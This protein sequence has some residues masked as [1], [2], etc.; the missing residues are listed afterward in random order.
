MIGSGS[1][2]LRIK[3][4][5]VHRGRERERQTGRQAD[6]ETERERNWKTG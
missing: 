5:K 6:K 2:M 1:Q 4:A 3:E